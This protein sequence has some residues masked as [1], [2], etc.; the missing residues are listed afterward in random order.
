M[1]G[2][3]TRG[4]PTN[5]TYHMIPLTYIQLYISGSILCIVNRLFYGQ[6]STSSLAEAP[7][8]TNV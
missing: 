5:V 7:M 3:L 8:R 1:N 2:Q 4:Y 6:D